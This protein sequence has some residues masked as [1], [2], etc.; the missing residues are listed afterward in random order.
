MSDNFVYYKFIFF[1]KLLKIRKSQ[2]YSYK[3]SEE[4]HIRRTI[5]KCHYPL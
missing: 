1:A 3:S 4:I 5:F 2:N